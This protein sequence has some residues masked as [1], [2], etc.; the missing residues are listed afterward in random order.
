M[1]RPRGGD[2]LYS[3]DEFEIMKK[4]IVVCKQS[5]CDGVVTGILTPDGN[6]DKKRCRE[7]V[8]FAYPLEVTFHRAF[9]PRK[10]S[11]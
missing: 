11:F 5:G 8:D 10:R 7:L 3:N 9:R 6:V 2:F 1:I 4:D